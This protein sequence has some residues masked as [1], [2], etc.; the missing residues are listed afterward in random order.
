MPVPVKSK[1][2]YAAVLGEPKYALTFD[3][4]GLCE[5]C[6]AEKAADDA[7]RHWYVR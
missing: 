2:S 6:C 5:S 4:F 3:H 7:F 1:E